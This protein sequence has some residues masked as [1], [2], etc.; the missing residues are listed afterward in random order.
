M[1]RSNLKLQLITASAS[2]FM[3][4]LGIWTQLYHQIRHLV[5]QGTGSSPLNH[6]TCRDLWIDFF[7]IGMLDLKV[8]LMK[9]KK[10][11]PRSEK[12]NKGQQISQ[13]A[14]KTRA[15][16]SVMNKSGNTRD[17]HFV[18]SGKSISMASIRRE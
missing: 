8:M 4:N 11:K 7:K 13:M 5:N 16:E 1:I 9:K 12:K 2:A 14:R 10:V 17:E 18:R 6:L 3:L 15:P